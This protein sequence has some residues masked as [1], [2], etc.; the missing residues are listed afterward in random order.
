MLHFAERRVTDV[1]V[2]YPEEYLVQVV[3]T[4][5]KLRQRPIS[6]SVFWD[7]VTFL[8]LAASSPTAFEASTRTTT[9]RPDDKLVEL[10]RILEKHRREQMIV[11]CE[12]QETA[13]ELAVAFAARPTFMVTGD[14]PVFEREGQVARFRSSADGVLIMTSVGAEGL[15]L[16]TCAALV[17]FDLTWNPMVLEQ[18][19]GR[20]DRIGQEKRAVHIY[21]MLVD[22]SIDERIIHVLGR[23]LGLLEGSIL[24]PASVLGKYNGAVMFEVEDF[25]TE[26]K[27]AQSLARALELSHEILPSDYSILPSIDVAYCAPDRLRTAA[28]AGNGLVWLRMNEA[29]VSWQSKL[30]LA[31]EEL[32]RLVAFYDS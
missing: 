19:I 15:D 26:L 14:V 4:I 9:S 11:F 29:A 30:L 5:K 3:A 1:A 16:Q 31:S 2:R 6:E 10:R 24:E 17:N 12:F 20:I 18:R 21:N 8:R 23:K 32:R 13:R 25:E 28:A 27:Q 7:E 22:G